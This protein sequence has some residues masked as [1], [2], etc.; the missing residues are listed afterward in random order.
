MKKEK[1]ILVLNGKL[2][3]KSKLTLFLK[4]YSK[5]ICVDGAANKVI[6]ANMK[7]DYIIGD[8]DSIS[9]I[10]LVKYKNKIVELKDQNYNDLQKALNWLKNN[11]TSNIDIIGF[12]GKRADHMI[13]N[14]N[15]IIDDINNFNIKIITERGTF[16]TVDKK[17]TFNNILNKSVSLFNKNPNNQI[18]SKGLKYE[19]KDRIL[20]NMYEG[21]LNLA[22]QNNI[23]VVTKY[24]ILIFISN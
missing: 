24:K 6:N 14:F 8:L 15:I 21:T 4:D 9:R 17:M 20:L 13:N 18:S 12:D 5:I 23:T 19:L 2:F 22:I 11:G 7:P 10:N 16:Y 3:K 1:I